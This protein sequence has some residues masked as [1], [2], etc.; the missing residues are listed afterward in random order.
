MSNLRGNVVPLD[1][2]SE[3][4]AEHFENIH[5]EDQ[6]QKNGIDL[7]SISKQKIRNAPPEDSIRGQ[8]DVEELNIIPKKMKNGKGPGPDG[9]RMELV[10]W[11]DQENRIALME[12]FNKWWKD[13]RAPPEIYHARVATIYEQG[14]TDE[15]GNYRPISLLSSFYKIYMMFLRERTQPITEPYVS[16]TQYGFRLCKSTAH[17]IYIIRRKQDFSGKPAGQIS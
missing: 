7:E 5:L 12:L 10:K 15:A 1:K 3:A 11:L 13:K 14:N 17:A 6:L 9:I 4:I 16:V 2:W 8:F